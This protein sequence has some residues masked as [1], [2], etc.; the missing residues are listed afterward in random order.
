MEMERHD[1]KMKKRCTAVVLAAGS[2]KR[3]KSSVA[4]QFI[5][6]DGKPLIWYALR[7]MCAGKSWGNTGLAKWT[8]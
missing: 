8:Q 2:G 4:K 5:Q 6:L 7:A 3:M 1:G